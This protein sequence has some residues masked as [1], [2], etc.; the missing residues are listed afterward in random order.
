MATKKPAAR[1][2]RRPKFH[3]RRSAAGWWVAI[4][5]A[6]GGVLFTSETYTRRTGPNKAVKAL[7]D[8]GLKLE[9]VDETKP[10]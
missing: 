6:N 9:L 5:G 3:L 1:P 10:A 7:A 4:V 2:P 8:A